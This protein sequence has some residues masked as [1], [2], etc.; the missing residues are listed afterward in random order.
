M[1]II[2]CSTWLLTR[3]K[4]GP[5][6][7][8]LTPPGGTGEN[9]QREGRSAGMRKSVNR[10]VIR[11]GSALDR[12]DRAA[13]L[14]AQRTQEALALLGFKRPPPD[15]LNQF[16]VAEC[17]IA[18]T[19]AQ[20]HAQDIADEDAEWFAEDDAIHDEWR[21]ARLEDPRPLGCCLPVDGT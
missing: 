21:A 1:A 16:L 8:A 10:H 18:Q 11:L 13:A 5:A 14:H 2:R 19:V 7:A 17:L 3:A 6:S 15:D 4:L 12:V 9:D 20:L